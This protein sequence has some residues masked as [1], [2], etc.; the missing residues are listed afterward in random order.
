[1]NLARPYRALGSLRFDARHQFKFRC[2]FVARTRIRLT[3]FQFWDRA[4]PEVDSTARLNLIYSTKLN[5]EP[6]DVRVAR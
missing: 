3:E 6:R 4:I 2:A 1:M 5:N